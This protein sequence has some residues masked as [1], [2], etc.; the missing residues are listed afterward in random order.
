MTSPDKT[1]NLAIGCEPLE[2]AMRLA[3]AAP[4]CLGHL[5]GGCAERSLISKMKLVGELKV[6]LRI[7]TMFRFEP[8]GWALHTVSR[9]L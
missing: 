6:S 2:A 4:I 1:G 8:L 5:H 7:M 9:F 3:N